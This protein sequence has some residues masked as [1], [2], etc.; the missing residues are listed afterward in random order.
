M[1]FKPES[2]VVLYEK[3]YDHCLEKYFGN[4]EFEG[5]KKHYSAKLWNEIDKETKKPFFF[6]FAGDKSRKNPNYF[7]RLYTKSWNTITSFEVDDRSLFLAFRE[8]KISV[9][10]VKGSEGIAFSHRVVNDVN[11]EFHKEFKERIQEV[12]NDIRSQLGL[13]P[14]K[15]K[16]TGAALPPLSEQ[17]LKDVAVTKDE[18]S[19]EKTIKDFL[20][21]ISAKDYKTA[22]AQLT[23]TF[24][25]RVW[26]GEFPKFERG[27]VNTA[28]IRKVHVF[29]INPDTNNSI[30]CQVHYEDEIVVYSCNELNAIALSTVSDIAEFVRNVKKLRNRVMKYGGKNF[31]KLEIY[32]LLEPTAAE[33]IWYKAGL[34]ISK[35][36]EVF[37]IDRVKFM[38]RLMFFTATKVKGKWRIESIREMKTYSLR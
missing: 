14:M 9:F 32:K 15:K 23:P 17:E 37:H 27:Y 33:Y 11:V 24:Q 1:D 21:S 38:K 6:R 10:K 5:A 16:D 25:Q 28:G 12:G 20:G 8:L 3:L 36:G 7:H 29:H 35:I 2:F 31:D 18:K 34:D 4:K 30:D 13:S 22:W 26:G 19:V